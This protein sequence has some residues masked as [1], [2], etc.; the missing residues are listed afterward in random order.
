MK[1]F[2]FAVAALGLAASSAHAQSVSLEQLATISLGTFGSGAAE[3]S[4][5]CASSQTLF[6]TNAETHRIE[7]LDLSALPAITRGAGIDITAYGAGVNSLAARQGV[8]AA[9]I[10]NADPT[11]SGWVV[12]FDSEGEHIFT[13]T[14]GVLPDMVAFSP[15]GS[16]LVVANEGEPTDDYATDPVGSISII[17][18]SGGLDGLDQDLVETVGFES[19]TAEDLGESVRIFGND[20]LSSIAE[21]LE[22]EYVAITPDGTKAYVT[23]QENN[24]VA[25]VDLQTKTL[26]GV[27]GQGFKDHNLPGNGL[28]A[29]NQDDQI[30]IQ[31]WPV[32]GM[33]QSDAIAAFEHEGEVYLVTAN[34]GDARDYEGYSEVA[35]VKDLDLDAVVFPDAASLQA[36]AYLGRLNITTSMGDIDED[37]DY[38]ALYCYGARSFSVWNADGELVFDS[39]DQ[40]EQQIAEQMPDYFNSTDDE[41]DSFDSRSDDKGP[42]PEAIAVGMVGTERYVFVGLERMG[43]I[44]VYELA[45]PAQPEF[46]GYVNNRDFTVADPSQEPA[47]DFAPEGLA[48]IAAANSPAPGGEPLLVVSN[49]ISGTVTIFALGAPTALGGAPAPG[50]SFYPNPGAEWLFLSQPS[51][52]QVFDLNGRLLLESG[53]T[54]ALDIRGLP[55]GSFL[56]RLGDSPARAFVKF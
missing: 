27:V 21:D 55:S 30:N 4:A 14:V 40:I 3:I 42:E 54:E 52:V 9:A 49:E 43:G 39:G 29:S 45:D 31:N 28:D 32:F 19:L 23:L 7:M 41:N 34:E 5:Y 10:E 44:M 38:D 12:L 46:V 1:R 47:G 8:V 15:N 53:R 56:I 11:Q 48:F 20:G 37:G 35:R 50:V 26:V 6:V 22:P 51:S 2:S 17:D 16:L 25:V 24:A 33:F 13:F 36:N 18:L